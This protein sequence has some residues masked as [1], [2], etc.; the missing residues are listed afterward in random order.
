M[1]NKRI[2]ELE[3]EVLKLKNELEKERTKNSSLLQTYKL[4]ESKKEESPSIR[5]KKGKKEKK[6]KRDKNKVR[7]ESTGENSDGSF[8]FFE[9]KREEKV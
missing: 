6:E 9:E 1:D 3:E 5:E 2:Q 8:D 4:D 7:E